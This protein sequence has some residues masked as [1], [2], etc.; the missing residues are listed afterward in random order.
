MSMAH[1]LAA[2]TRLA[3]RP[4][5]DAYTHLAFLNQ[6]S[7][8][9]R[10]TRGGKEVLYSWEKQFRSTALVFWAALNHVLPID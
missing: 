10:R 9:A 7:P 3:R 8:V 5:A 6:S 1:H 2:L 4:Q